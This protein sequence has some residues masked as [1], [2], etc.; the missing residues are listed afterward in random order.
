MAEYSRAFVQEISAL[1]GKQF[2]TLIEKGEKV[3]CIVML[4]IYLEKWI[5]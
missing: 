3:F 4:Q 2:K 1:L 5:S